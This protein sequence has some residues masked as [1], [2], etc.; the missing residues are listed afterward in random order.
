MRFDT[1]I[2]GGGLAGLVCAL[3]LQKRGQDCA[4]VS[5]GHSTLHFNCGS[6]GL[7]SSLEDGTPVDEPIEAFER[8][9]PEHPYSVIGAQRAAELAGNIPEVFAS[10]SIPLKGCAERNGLAIS[11]LGG[12][13]P[14]AFVTGDS[15]LLQDKP[16][17]Q[18][19]II[20]NFEGY[21]DFNSQF[22]AGELMHLGMTVRSEFYRSP[23]IALLRK[24]P[25]EMRAVA[26]GRLMTDP[27]ER[28][29]FIEGVKALLKDED[30]VVL[31]AVFGLKDAG[32]AMEVKAGIPVKTVLVGTMPPSVP[33]SRIEYLLT[34]AFTGAGGTLLQGD[35]AVKAEME[36][37]SIKSIRTEKLGD[38]LLEA[39]NFVLATGSY[40]SMG[41]W[42]TQNSVNETLFG[43][44]TD[45]IPDRGQWCD[46]DFFADQK[47][48]SFGVCTDSELRP[49][50]DGV[51]IPNLR[52]I[53]SLLGGCNPLSMG[54]G[55]GVAIITALAAAESISKE[56]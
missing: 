24:S 41:L 39:R 40:V 23:R 21:H 31:P 54:C 56:G 30:L 1:V 44:D 43:L 36:A 33:G 28:N 3:E 50:K 13:Y 25:S 6:F 52:A 7:L 22:I 5:A 37:G 10:Y 15:E 46:E 19:A 47:Y 8:L 34:K 53:G 11:P 35:R 20:V 9:S 26:I 49:S 17:E 45:F 38:C 51:T 48:L 27:Q 4:V 12:L 29:N 16:K 32:A 42:A 18:K 14:T 55:A 2:I